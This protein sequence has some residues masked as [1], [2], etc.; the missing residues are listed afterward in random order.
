MNTIKTIKKYAKENN[1]PIMM[2]EGIEF[3][4]DYIKENSVQ[5]I[6]E[7]GTAI[8]FSSIK[9]AKIDPRIL[10]DTCEIKEELVNLAK[11]NIQ[12]NEVNHQI[13][14]YCMDALDFQTDKKYDLIFVDAAKAQYKKYMDHFIENLSDQGVFIFDNL[15]FHGM[16]NHP[17][18]AKSRNTKQLVRKLREFRDYLINDKDLKTLYYP[19]IGD[20]VA[21]VSIKKKK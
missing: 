11:K 5:H 4:C 7:C 21:V 16:V 6:L 18:M 20:G 1:V 19:E 17:E 2:D 8:G 14:V 13:T 15:E 12:E 3:L 9:M 10:I